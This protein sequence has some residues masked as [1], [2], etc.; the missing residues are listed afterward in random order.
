MDATR[1]QPLSMTRFVGE[2]K[3]ALLVALLAGAIFL[4]GQLLYAQLVVM[5]RRIISGGALAVG[6]DIWWAARF[7]AIAFVV[8]LAWQMWPGRKGR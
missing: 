7:A 8:Y 1:N 3:V 4:F 2:V 6:V 5:P